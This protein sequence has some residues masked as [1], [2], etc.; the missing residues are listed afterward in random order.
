MQNARIQYQLAHR[1]C[2]HVMFSMKH[3]NYS[4]MADVSQ[5][6]PVETLLGFELVR[7]TRSCEGI[8]SLAWFGDL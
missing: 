1:A 5:I 7:L 3:F 4:W 8:C 6:E 2:S